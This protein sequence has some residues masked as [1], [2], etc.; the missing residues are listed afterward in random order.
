[1]GKYEQLAKDIIKNVGGKENIKSL[2][3]C[4]TRLRFQL[5]DESKAND[6]V[7]K[8]MDGIV[9]ILKSAGQYQ[10]VIGNHVSK[11]YEDVCEVAGISSESESKS[12]DN[13]NKKPFDKFID[14]ISGIFQPILG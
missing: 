4:I 6:A 1:M 10:V 13:K 7:L 9:T 5:D 12:E 14:V 2:T 11:V 3:H 8:N